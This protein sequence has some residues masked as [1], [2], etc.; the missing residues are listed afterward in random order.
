[1]T[2][3]G[4]VVVGLLILVL[5]I[6]GMVG[7]YESEA[8]P[9]GGK[10]PKVI[11]DVKA[12]EPM[13]TVVGALTRDGVIGSSLAFRLWTFA[14]GQP[15]VRP[16]RY[17]LSRN[18]SFAAVSADLSAGPNVF[19]V[20]VIPGTTLAEIANQLS[21][22]PGN[23]AQTFE[24]EARTGA[25]RSPFQLVPGTSLEG[26]IGT[27]TYQILPGEPARH[28]LGAMV[29]RFD[30]EAKAA[31]LS[32]TTTVNGENA[33]D[34]VIVASIAEKEG[35]FTRYFGKV[36]RVVYNRLAQGMAL[37]MTSTVLYSL[38]QDGGPVTPAEERD[39][40]PYNTYLHTGLTPTPI[41]TPSAAALAAAVAPP[42]G[43]WLYFE[44]VTAKKGVMVFSATYTQQLAAERE[45]A[46]KRAA[47]AAQG[48]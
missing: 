25:V 23:L 1:M 44:L 48:T 37:D 4:K 10:G 18:L 35:Y 26:L 7:W 38:G 42:A 30:A 43:P 11:V 15:Q 47:S 33:Y 17:L 2:L 21:S 34:A 14:H 32:P 5:L 9:F 24:N 12:G 27:G 41:C 45:A 29:A 40:T 20:N 6:A 16:G 3:R 22:L 39:T 8:N 19:E 13:G 28:L 31:G 46:A 36:S